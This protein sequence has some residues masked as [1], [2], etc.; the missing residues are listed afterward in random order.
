MVSVLGVES[1]LSPTLA[2][3]ALLLIVPSFYLWLGALV[4]RRLG[5]CSLFLGFTWIGVELALTPLGLENG[6]LAGTQGRGALVQLVGGL[7]GSVFVGFLIAF[8]NALLLWLLGRVRVRISTAISAHRLGGPVAWHPYGQDFV[9]FFFDL[10]S[11]ARPRAP[12]A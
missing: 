5:Y 3:L 6:L 7:L 11:P 4:T 8:A 9:H 1:P 12:P 10:L 2:S